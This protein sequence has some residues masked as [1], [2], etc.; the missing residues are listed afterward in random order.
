MLQ[1]LISAVHYNQEAERFYEMD[2]DT[3]LQ[4]VL[5]ATLIHSGL[6]RGIREPPKP[7]TRTKPVFACLCLTMVSRY[8]G[9]LCAEPQVNLIK[10]DDKTLGEWVGLWDWPR[11]GT[12]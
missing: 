12:P 4:E 8:R 10:V 3:A 11:G 9:R 7:Q 5:K 2:I 6:A 1:I